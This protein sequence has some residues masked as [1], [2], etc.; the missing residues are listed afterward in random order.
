MNSGLHHNDIRRGDQ[1]VPPGHVSSISRGAGAPVL[2]VHGL[3]A[4]LYDWE[5]LIP[6]LTA[7]GYASHALDLL[8]HGESFKPPHLHDYHVN[9]VFEHMLGWADGLQLREPAILIGHS[10]G[11]YLSLQYALRFPDR[12]RALVLVDP[13]YRQEQLSPF[14]QAMFRRELKNLILLERA[15]YWLYRL[16]IDFS[17]FNFYVD[18][19]ELHSLP[20]RVRLQ[21]ALDYKRAA[22]GIYNLP[23]TLHDLTSDLPS[24]RQPALVLWG[25]RDQTL[26]PASFPRLVEMLANGRGEA[27]RTCGHVPHQCHPEGFNRRVL[28]FLA[29]L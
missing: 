6:E 1:L 28:D 13:L 9:G 16:V 11:G 7:A 4:S 10:L 19:R 3:A 25:A 8:G 2:L 17:S 18:Q 14:L 5:A 24:L 27:I 29:S 22:A 23:R 26:S 21:T 15:P 20:G 12:V